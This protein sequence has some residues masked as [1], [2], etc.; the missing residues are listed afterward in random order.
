MTG[1]FSK[2]CT[3]FFTKKD[4]S[5]CSNYKLSVNDYAESRYLALFRPMI[6]L[7]NWRHLVN[8]LDEIVTENKICSCHEVCFTNEKKPS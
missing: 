3:K 1:N 8:Q 6:G 7:K 5:K 2:I 4:N